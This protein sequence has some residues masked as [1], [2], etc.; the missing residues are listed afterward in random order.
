MLA[1]HP[2]LLPRSYVSTTVERRDGELRVAFLP[3]PASEED[4]GLTWPAL[5]T[6]A[7]GHR[8]IEVVAGC[9]APQ[10]RVVVAPPAEGEL[11]A[12]TISIDPDGEPYAEPSEVLLT[13]FSTGALFEFQR[14]G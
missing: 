13:E 9:T 5:L 1:V 11:A 3:C 14:R 7:D 12:W 2:L 8:M 6:H 10:A 4:D